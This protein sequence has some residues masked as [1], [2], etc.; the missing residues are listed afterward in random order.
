MEG[1]TAAAPDIYSIDSGATHSYL[2]PRFKQYVA[3]SPVC[4]RYREDHL[5][6]GFCLSPSLVAVTKVEHVRG[7]AP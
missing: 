2:W 4:L 5:S 6:R 1:A 3:P 7:S